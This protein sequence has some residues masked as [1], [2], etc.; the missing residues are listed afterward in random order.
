MEFSEAMG[1]SQLNRLQTAKK[2]YAAVLEPLCRQW[3]LTRN[4][5]NVLLFLANNPEFDRAA[6]IVTIRS[7]AKSHVSLAVS[8]LERRG[9]LTRRFDPG[10]RR[11]AHLQLTPEAAPVI[12]GGLALQQQFFRGIFSGFTPEELAL[13]RNLADRVLENAEQMEV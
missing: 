11:T 9:F 7:I 5:L 3:D 4:E 8:S 2:K 10:D 13:W 12:A 6:D 1:R